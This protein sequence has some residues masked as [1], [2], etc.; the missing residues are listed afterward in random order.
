MYFWL[1]KAAYWI[2]L[3]KQS[4]IKFIAKYYLQLS[5]FE[6][7]IYNKNYGFWILYKNP[8][9]PHW[10]CGFVFL[11]EKTGGFPIPNCRFGLP[12][13]IFLLPYSTIYQSL[14]SQ[15]FLCIYYLSY[16][17]CKYLYLFCINTYICIWSLICTVRQ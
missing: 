11:Y 14:F 9:N 4:F 5:I 10:N 2:I 8:Q 1:S 12:S 7:K 17:Q 15:Y 16:I 3:I 6:L 13:L